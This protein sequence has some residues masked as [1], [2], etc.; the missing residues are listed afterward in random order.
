[1]EIWLDNTIFSLQRAGGISGIWA[2]LISRLQ[3]IAGLR[4]RYVER[5]DAADNIF[6]QRLE[7]PA[8]SIIDDY[9][10]PLILT[11]YM[12]VRT[13]AACPFIF[14]SPYYRRCSSQLARNVV[15][16]HDFV[17]ER[18]GTHGDI[19]TKVHVAQKTDALRH[20]DAIAA[21]SASALDDMHELYPDINV[22]STVIHN[23][24]ICIPGNPPGRQPDT[25]DYALFV[26][27]RAGYKNFHLAA[28]AVKGTHI[29][30]T[31]AGAPLNADE[32]D[33]Y[34]S[35]LDSGQMTI[36][37]YPGDRE[38]SRLYTSAL[39]LLYPSDYEGFGIPI[40]EAQA[41]GCPVITS[42]CRACL[43]ASGNAVISLSE[44]TARAWRRAMLS[45]TEPGSRGRLIAAGLRNAAGYSA[46]T[47]AQKYVNLYESL[48]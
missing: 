23:A 47:M 40:V 25:P 26:G 20:A 30:L 41:H 42:A 17:Y 14:H 21:V 4:L 31:V 37:E 27:A 18:C 32:K 48:L 2:M 38:L 12:R 9:R 24:P 34:A 39:C 16:L 13:E 46:E 15:T 11:R 8:D 22:R 19:A 7:I 6:R 1:M 35:M 29:R 44:M 36:V 5:P 3:K 33:K 10:L 43:E 45:L 28:E